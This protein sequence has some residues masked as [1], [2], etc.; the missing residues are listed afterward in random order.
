[1]KKNNIF[2]Y[3]HQGWENAPIVSK[4]CSETWNINKDDYNIIKLDNNNLKNY[5]DLDIFKLPNSI[6]LASLSDV[7]RIT[8][9]KEYGGIW[10]DS[11]LYCNKKITNWINPQSF[12]AFSYP[13]PERMVSSWFL[14]SNKNNYII[15][16]WYEQTL[17]HWRNIGHNHDYF[18][19][20]N[21]FNKCYNND[22]KFK[23]E[24]DSVNNK[25]SADVNQK[26]GP[27]RFTPYN[28]E[29]NKKINDSI[30]EDIES[31]DSPV[32]KLNWTFNVISDTI[33]D[34]LITKKT[35]YEKN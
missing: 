14:H 12:F 6:S 27:H 13:V 25:I 31:D 19:F 29:F 21:L 8:L 11:T 35:Y 10:V 3:W 32:F 15:E 28:I 9:L 17:W 23:F 2:I 7:I 18:W 1:M 5:I 4:K 33:L 30:I 22:D 20:H 34:Y 16:K 24:W 26:K